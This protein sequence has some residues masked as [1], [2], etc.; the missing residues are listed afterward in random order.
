M[1]V[2]IVRMTF[3][4]DALDTFLELYDRVSPAIRAQ[5]GCHGL[6][7]VREV[8]RP[9]VLSTVSVWDTEGALESYRGSELFR[10][11]W[12][13]TRTFFDA[14]AEAWSHEVIRGDPAA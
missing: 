5:P 10:T 2:R 6:Q 1:I 12:S 3:R 13:V 9:S 8:D 11:T 4:P 14:P 7:L